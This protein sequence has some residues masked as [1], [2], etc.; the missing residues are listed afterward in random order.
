M[1]FDV[2]L[3][4]GQVFPKHKLSSL[5]EAQIVKV[6]RST[7]RLSWSTNGQFFLKAERM[8]E[9]ANCQ[10]FWSK[11]PACRLEPQSILTSPEGI[12]SLVIWLKTLHHNCRPELTPGT[13]VQNPTRVQKQPARML[14]LGKRTPFKSLSGFFDWPSIIPVLLY[15]VFNIVASI[16]NKNIKN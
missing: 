5:F 2:Q 1:N 12:Q 15:S 11:C 6:F 14:S 9:S 4:S 16:G 3:L 7:I 13:G 10:F 8:H